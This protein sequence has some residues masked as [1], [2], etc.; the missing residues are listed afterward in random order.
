M[1][2]SLLKRYPRGFTI[3]EL[4]VVIV[5]IS[6]LVAITVISYAGFAQKATIASLQSDLANISI[7]L[8]L[9][10]VISGAYPA[11]LAL[12]NN[13]AGI[14][15]C[16]GPTTCQYTVNNNASPQ[17]YNLYITKNS[18][19]YHI[20]NDSKPAIS[21]QVIATGGTVSDVGGFRVHTFTVI[22]GDQVEVLVVAGGGGGG[23][24]ALGLGGGGG[25]GAG[26]LIYNPSYL[27]TPGSISV[28][29]GSGGASGGSE[30]NQLGVNGE[31]S[32][33]G[34]LTALGGGFGAKTGV[35][36]GSGGSGGGGGYNFYSAIRSG[37]TGVAGQ[38]NSGGSTTLLS[39]AGG[40][41]GGGAGGVGGNNKI[42]HG[43]GDRGVGLTF[44]ISGNL[45]TYSI[46]GSGGTWY[47][48]ASPANIGKGGDAAYAG[49]IPYDGGSGVVIVR[50]PL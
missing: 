11:T 3:V 10:Q 4:L 8:K 45:V 22:S 7:Q 15:L 19:K 35:D 28:I 13:G 6:I 39:W 33:F 29:I 25:G 30:L 23:S 50:Y 18:I 43:G 16:A 26:G 17:T 27:I 49:L 2:I 24:S 36:G 46:G 12:A 42:S 1:K 37:G 38:G 47:P 34:T 9:D 32:V 20:T 21:N 5:V 48:A 14:S 31:D 41:G 40:A 44:N